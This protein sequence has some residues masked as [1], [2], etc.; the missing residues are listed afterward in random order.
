MYHAVYIG[1]VVGILDERKL[2]IGI[3]AS[4][5]HRTENVALIVHKEESVW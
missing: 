5:F 1:V 4:Y 3:Y 2:L